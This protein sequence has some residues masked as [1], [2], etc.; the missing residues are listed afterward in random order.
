M[1]ALLMM[2]ASHWLVHREEQKHLG[3]LAQRVLERGESAV[4]EAT[5]ALRAVRDLAPQDYCTA[6]GT[7]RFSQVM[8]RT[9][10]LR[11]VG[12]LTPDNR[13]CSSAGARSLAASLPAPRWIGSDYSVW[14]HMGP[15]LGLPEGTVV[16]AL[17]SVFAAIDPFFLVDAVAVSDVQVALL[18]AANGEP[19][20]TTPGADLSRMSA[21]RLSEAVVEPGHETYVSRRHAW[22]P[23][24]VVVSQTRISHLEQWRNEAWLWVPLGVIF[25]GLGG[26]A[27]TAVMRQAPEAAL[28]R[29]LVKRAF[30]VFYQPIVEL[31]T[32]RCA[33]AEALV[34]WRRPD[35]TLLRPDLFIPLAEETGLVLA[36]TDQV[37]E[38]VVTELGA[39][40]RSEP[41]YV[42]INLSARDVASTRIL[43]L[44]AGFWAPRRF[45]QTESH[46]RSPS[47]V[48]SMPE[49]RGRR[50]VATTMPATGS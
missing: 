28:R 19:L 16:I 46:S 13:A 50:C 9:H 48:R 32:G 41:V 23:A 4:A 22:A 12:G 37:L 30:V 36:L 24:V 2:Q 11:A 15:E 45:R 1:A 33:G 17:G 18:D 40:L 31:A 20:A 49:T 34:R 25:G 35:G 26:L 27:A 8:S 42:S 6:R 5:H 3:A 21:A 10:R 7:E 29:A 43:G 39:L 14:L 38:N 44:A 47:G